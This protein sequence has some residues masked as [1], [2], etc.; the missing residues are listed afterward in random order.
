M[1]TQFRTEIADIPELDAVVLQV[2]GDVDAQT[3]E[4]LEDTM[5][6]L[7]GRGVYRII[8][9]LSEVRYLASAGVGVLISALC[10]ARERGGSVVLM[11]PTETVYNVLELLGI[12]AVFEVAS[13]RASA[14]AAL[15][16]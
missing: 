4:Q 7:I 13:D 15:S 10:Q 2:K 9:E 14:L 3:F 16:R 6:S 11:R 5:G 12:L 8:V 1:I